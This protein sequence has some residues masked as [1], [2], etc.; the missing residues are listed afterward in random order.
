MLFFR[1]LRWNSS[2]SRAAFTAL[3]IS[4]PATALAAFVIFRCWHPSAH[5]GEKDGSEFLQ[6]SQEETAGH[7]AGQAP[8]GIDVPNPATTPAEVVAS[9][10]GDEDNEACWKCLNMAQVE[11]RAAVEQMEDAR[12]PRRRTSELARTPDGDMIDARSLFRL[13]RQLNEVVEQATYAA[14]RRGRGEL[15][16]QLNRELEEIFS[17]TKT[18]AKVFC[19]AVASRSSCM[20]SQQFN[21]L[22]PELGRDYIGP[23]LRLEDS[24]QVRLSPLISVPMNA[25]KLLAAVEALLVGPYDENAYD[26]DQKMDAVSMGG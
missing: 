14:W 15:V 13:A 19:M 16:T 18:R 26:C 17:T 2:S 10:S 24:R 7:R 22:L 1:I 25:K 5:D 9:G 6:T 4:V 3:V 21:N 11:V 20:I 8:I 12:G 23:F